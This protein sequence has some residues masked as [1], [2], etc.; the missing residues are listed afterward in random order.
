M[1]V[2]ARS[3]DPFGTAQLQSRSKQVEGRQ[4]VDRRSSGAAVFDVLQ[5][6]HRYAVFVALGPGSVDAAIGVP[7]LL[8]RGG[9]H[10]AP[11]DLARARLAPSIFVASV[12]L[13]M[14]LPIS[15][16][17]DVTFRSNTR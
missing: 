7:L 14:I 9:G 16:C 11:S 6:G 10:R 13:P 5:I 17:I 2:P 1:H 3:E 8:A 12:D 4:K 15:P